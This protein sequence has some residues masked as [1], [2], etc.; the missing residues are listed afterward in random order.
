MPAWADDPRFQKLYRTLK[1]QLDGDLRR[2]HSSELFSRRCAALFSLLDSE[3]ADQ[4]Q[5]RR[6]RRRRR[7]W[8]DQ[9]QLCQAVHMLF[10]ANRRTPD[11][12]EMAVGP[13]AQ[14]ACEQL[15]QE[16]VPGRVLLPQF[17]DYMAEVCSLIKGQQMV[18]WISR[19]HRA[20]LGGVPL[21]AIQ[22]ELERPPD[23][24]PR[25]H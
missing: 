22:V 4:Q 16:G 12:V 10:E 11:G 14:E 5:Q 20:V 18:L 8:L 2:E 24:D 1:A 23:R 3:E 19:I 13:M 9:E 15:M 21:E 7:H 17:R 25:R 6:R